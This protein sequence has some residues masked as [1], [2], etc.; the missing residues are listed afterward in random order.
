M[1]LL[2]GANGYCF[3]HENTRFDAVV[4]DGASIAAVGTATELRLQ[5]AGHI[6]R[7]LDVGGATVI[8]GLVDS[9]LHVAALGEQSLALDLTGVGS[10]GELLARVTRHASKLAPGAWVQGSGWDDNR[11]QGG[12]PTIDELDHAAGG[13]PVLLTRVCR[14]A[15]LANRVAFERAGLSAS[16]PDPV[17]GRYGR[18]A[19]G[20]LNGWV[21]ENAARPFLRAIPSWTEVDWE[22][23]L[24]VGMRSALAVGVTAVHTDDT[25]NLGGFAPTWRLYRRLLER[26]VRLRVH[27]L[28]DWHVLSEA[29]MVLL[30][31]EGHTTAAQAHDTRQ[32]SG[33][34]GSSSE[35]LT[36]NGGMR[37]S[38]RNDLDLADWL[39]VGAAKLFS[40]GAFGGRT[41]WLSAPYSDASETAGTPMYTV[42]ELTERVQQARRLGFPVAIHC[43]GDAALDAVLT[44]LER[45]GR[46][47]RAIT[48]VAR[49][50][51]IHAELVRPDLL[52]RMARLGE[53]AVID[54]QPRFVPSDFPWVAD[55][56]GPE[57][58]ASVG[59]WRTMRA[60][61]LH[62]A[63]G[64]D[65]P[66]EPVS[67]LLGVHAAVTRRQPDGTEPGYNLAE[68]LTPVE[69]IQLFTSDA[70]FAN[71]SEGRKGRIVA[72]TLADFTVIDRDVVEPRHPDDIRDAKVLRTIVG[73]ET[74]FE[75]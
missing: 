67:P 5:F 34:T 65:A 10:R 50:R 75:V 51:I 14:H 35:G 61:G 23:A 45:A 32:R 21:Y 11:M 49:D 62:L 37:L 20:K 73:G 1:W 4:V 30:G 63:G 40:D 17:D 66:I 3:D 8:P 24:E 64:S 12:V 69:A 57:R 41:A 68:A 15:Y 28:V 7:T 47:T 6:E 27:E 60:R 44:A 71:G 54:V 19:S 9:H 74:A 56:L 33:Q 46:P 13:R 48:P 52:H 26:G 25:R 2:T 59:A 72:G 55:R 29:R 18:D 38:G 53:S 70:C 36:H 31:G 43:I 42:E 58:A 22:H 16:L 39:E